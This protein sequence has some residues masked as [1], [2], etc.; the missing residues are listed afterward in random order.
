LVNYLNTL[1]LGNAQ[2]LENVFIGQ[3]LFGAD[4]LSHVEKE[5]SISGYKGL[6]I[7]PFIMTDT[8][9][10]GSVLDSVAKVK[11]LIE[12]FDSFGLTLFEN[13]LIRLTG[14][15]GFN[16]IIPAGTI[17]YEPREDFSD[18]VYRFVE[19]LLP[20]EGKTRGWLN[21]HRSEDSDYAREAN[22]LKHT[23]SSIY[24]KSK[25]Y[26]L[27]C[28]KNAPKSPEENDG[29][30]Y[31]FCLYLDKNETEAVFNNPKEI[32]D[33]WSQ[34][35]GRGVTKE[36]L[37]GSHFWTY[38]PVPK[39]QELWER[40]IELAKTKPTYHLVTGSKGSF[41]PLGALA[42]RCIKKAWDVINNGG[43]GVDK[44]GKTVDLLA[45]RCNDTFEA[46]LPYVYRMFP[47]EDFFCAAIRRLNSKLEKPMSSSS[48]DGML[49]TFLKNKYGFSCG[50][51]SGRGKL[52]QSFCGGYCSK[53]KRTWVYGHEAYDKMNKFWL[54]GDS[55]V[56]TGMRFWDEMFRGHLP[57]QVVCFQ[58]LP[59]VGKTSFNG[60][61]FRHQVPI[62][63]QHDKIC[64]FSTP[65]ENHEIIQTYLSMQQGEM[66]LSRLKEEIKRDGRANGKIQDFNEKYGR[67]YVL[68]YIRGKTPKAIRENLE[69]IRQNSGKN[70]FS[71]ILDSVTFIKPDNDNLQGAARAESVAN[72]MEDIAAE[73]NTTLFISIHLPKFEA[74]NSFG[75]KRKQR[76][77]D[78]RPSLV[79]AK[80]TVDWAGLVS[81]LASIYTRG[82]RV[83]MLAPE[84]GRLRDDGRPLPHPQPYLR[85]GHY[86]LYSLEE[87]AQLYGDRVND[88]F[89]VDSYELETIAEHGDHELESQE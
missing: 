46:I 62:G 44:D 7:S 61:I 75:K 51:D 28:T 35:N 18:V 69:Q 49:A 76:L 40:A 60:R 52:L 45:G 30:P 65:E 85:S 14:H 15:K 37:D 4:F 38:K 54:Q 10:K 31:G 70:F 23:D 87:A 8:D 66:T 9:E 41:N 64:V 82:D 47:D 88:V 50:N 59:G 20:N 79:G 17:G 56:T 68:D 32:F 81:H 22:K 57:G 11:D 33:I 13:M 84:K 39:L 12:H 6:H 36:Y 26:R 72:A 83:V 89:G 1:S 67:D 86:M 5:K 53:E 3:Y 29:Q 34:P 27:P 73:F 19:L 21:W 25:L 16:L 24:E 78:G 58:S 77:T 74:Y 63:K 80:G 71:I 2:N 43:L 48:V 55:P 42:P